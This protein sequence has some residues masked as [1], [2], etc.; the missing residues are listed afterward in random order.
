MKS[1][2]IAPLS[3]LAVALVPSVANALTFTPT[4]STATIT[5]SPTNLTPGVSTPSIPKFDPAAAFA[6]FLAQNPPPTPPPGNVF[7]GV[8]LVGVTV[9]YEATLRLTQ[10]AFRNEGSNDG[11]GFY[12]SRAPLTGQ[13][14]INNVRF[15]APGSLLDVSYGELGFTPISVPSGTLAPGEQ[16]EPPITTAPQTRSLTRSIPVGSADLSNFVGT[17]S[18]NFDVWTA[19]ENSGGSTNFNVVVLGDPNL[20]I[21]F[22][23]TVSYEYEP[24]F[25]P[26]GPVVPEPSSLL[27][28][29]LFGLGLGSTTLRKKKK[30]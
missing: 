30:A 19:I 9:N 4:P 15:D 29:G 13:E 2:L 27:G 28:L 11:E 22:R 18:Y 12:T 26:F 24:N 1:W 25:E 3:T 17:G 6:G 21:D 23:A 8:S 7:T 14:T 20:N 5:T 16:T 10:L